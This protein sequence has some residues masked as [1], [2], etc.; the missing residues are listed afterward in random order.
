MPDR[1]YLQI[2]FVYSERRFSFGK[3]YICLPKFLAAPII[4]IGSQHIAAFTQSS[5]ISPVLYF[6]PVNFCRSIGSLF[7]I[8]L[9]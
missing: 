2:A 8:G 6:M 1:P 3:L 5:P 7:Y 4:Y 9:E